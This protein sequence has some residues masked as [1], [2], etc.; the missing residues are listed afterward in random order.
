[1][2][3]VWPS[4]APS[5]SEMMRA[6]PSVGPPGGNG[7]MILIGCLAG[8]AWA[9]SGLAAR[10]ATRSAAAAHSAVS[11]K[12]RMDCV[13]PAL[14]HRDVGVFHHAGPKLQLAVEH[15]LELARRADLD[16]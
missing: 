5:R 14:F 16:V 2:T 13:M 4:T 11:S 1:M 3:M 10:P 6:M 7:T 8:Q 15:L 9:C 12:V